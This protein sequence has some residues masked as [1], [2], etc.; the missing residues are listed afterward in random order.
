MPLY[1]FR[2]KKCE[3]VW[4]EIADHDKRGK[5]SG[6]SCP[7]CKSKSKEK[8][9]TSCTFKFSNPVG[10]DKWNSDSTGHDFRHKYNMERPGGVSEQRAFAEENSHV[11]ARP[12][13]EAERS[14]PINDIDSDS[15]WGEVK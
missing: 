2:C 14:N 9:L 6:V 15:S 3:K 10:T 8:L 5:Y 4:E 13:Q 1:A 7:G 11:G 12:Y